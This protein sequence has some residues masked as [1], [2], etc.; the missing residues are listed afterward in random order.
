M[1]WLYYWKTILQL[2]AKNGG[3]DELAIHAYLRGFTPDAVTSNSRMSAP[4]LGQ[5]DSFRTYRDAL[6]VVPS[7][8]RGLPVHITECNE[9]LPDGWVD[10]NTGIVKA[11]YREIHEWNQAPDTQKIHSLTLYRWP[12]KDKWYI[13]GK[14]GVILDFREAVLQ[15]FQSPQEGQE[16]PLNTIL[17]PSIKKESKTPSS[18]AFQRSE[19]PRA[20]ARGVNI[21]EMPF[22]GD[23]AIWKVVKTQWLDKEQ[24]QGRHH[25]YFET[26]DENG[27][28]LVN[29]PILVSWPS[30]NFTVVSEEKKGEPYSANYPMS[31]SRNEYSAIVLGQ[32]L[33]EM[34]RGIGMGADLGSGFNAGEHTSTV[35]V[36]QRI[37]GQQVDF[38]PTI[39]ISSVKA[40]ISI[41]H[42]VQ[43]PKFRRITQGWKERPDYYSRFKVDGVP[44][45]GHNGIDYGTP[46]GSVIVAVD[47]GKVVENAFDA[48]GYG[49]YVK[50]VHTWGESLYAHLSSATVDVGDI[51]LKGQPL[52]Y[53]GN[54]GNSTGPHLH[55]GLRIN[56]FNRKDGMGGYSNPLGF[57]SSQIPP[58]QQ[59]PTGNILDS[60]KAAANETNLEWELLASLAWAESSFRPEIADGLFQIGGATW[61]DWASRLGAT[62]ILNPLDNAR[63]AAH[64]LK[65]LLGQLDGNVYKALIAYNFGIN[66]VLAGLEPPQLT[67]EYVNKVIHGRDLLKAVG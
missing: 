53:S 1:D 51:A 28:R 44:L 22:K 49:Y 60:I 5:Y 25:I 56:P 2:I 24:S 37:K 15:S 20:R 14:Q 38:D 52:G 34:V 66:R 13:E 6:S 27:K 50:I 31:P 45:Q 12:K 17:V 61:S 30:G 47:D 4:L 40:M 32:G 59:A 18:P 33:S 10:S 42:P 46:I 21:V 41:I 3:C 43:D 55:F 48:F 65:W 7:P 16:G 29:V 67:V 63:V 19:D 8:L 9:L 23:E 57:L 36:F 58:V 54:S 62:N 11:A 26:L 39:S 35:V 64:Y